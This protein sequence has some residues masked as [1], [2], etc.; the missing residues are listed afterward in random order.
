MVMQS[1]L[2]TALGPCLGPCLV[3]GLLLGLAACGETKTTVIDRRPGDTSPTW[4]DDKP[5]NTVFGKGGL[6]LFG[7]DKKKDQDQNGAGI[8]VNFFLWRA[9][10]DTISFMPLA[11]AD[12]FGGVIITDWYS[13]PESGAER[14]KMTV[15]ILDRALR[16]DGV[17]VSVFRQVQNSAGEWADAAVDPKTSTDMENTI[18]TRARE[19]RTAAAAAK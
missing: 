3:L 8:G 18:L 6:D 15:L 10:L 11:S 19:I 13:P 17:R 12:P 1:K 9:S 4:G 14:F 5:Q 7:G 2:R 16:A